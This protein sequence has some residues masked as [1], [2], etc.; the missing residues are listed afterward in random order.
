MNLNIRFKGLESSEALKKY[1]DERTQKLAK[2]LPPSVVVNA[3]LLEDKNRKSTEI[4]FNYKGNNYVAKQE[5]E[6]MF[7]SIDEVVDKLTRQL[8]RA[9]DKKTN[10]QAPPEPESF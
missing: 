2:F 5:T 1:L 6:S 8:A 7:A 10:R 3:T 9:K 4:N